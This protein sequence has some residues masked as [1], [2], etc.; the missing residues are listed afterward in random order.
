MAQKTKI[1]RKSDVYYLL[2]FFFVI[3]FGYF[4]WVG[5]Y[6]LF[7]QEQ[8][9]LF[10][11]SGEYFQ[12]YILK[13]GGFLELAGK[14]LT[15]FYSISIVGSLILATILTLPA[16]VLLKINQRLFSNKSFILLLFIPSSLL[17]LM[18]THYFHQIE[19]NLGFLMVLLYFLISILVQKKNIRLFVLALFPLFYYLVG[20]YAWIFLGMYSLYNL[21][22]EKRMLR[23]VYPLFLVG[24]ATVSFFVFK[25]ILFLQP[26]EQ[27]IQFPLPIVD[28]KNHKFIL[29]LLTGLLVLYPLLCKIAFLIKPKRIN[30]RPFILISA[31]IIFSITILFLS[32][33]YNSQTARVIQLQKLAFE[34]K[35]NEVLELHENYPSENLIG[36]YFYNI[37][38]SETD[39]LCDRLF[40]GRQDFSAN[41]LVLPW[42]SEH[43]N[44]GTYFF[45]SVGLI[46]E[47]HRWAYEEMVVYGLRPQNIKLLVKTNLINGNLEMANKYINILKKTIFYNDWAKEFEGILNNPGLI[48]SHPKLGEKIK[49]LPKEDF[50]I[51]I[52]DPQNN[53]PL[54]LKS[55]PNNKKAFEYEMAWLLLTKDVEAIVN[56]IKKMKELG[57]S[58]IP[59][60]IEE[61]VLIYF[62][63]KGQFPDLGGLSISNKTQVRFQ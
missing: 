32:K 49:I 41:S 30:T 23:F 18:Q 13:P 48:K 62:N 57:Y 15:Q 16:I 3:S 52:S 4:Y 43:L 53:I 47:A 7:F 19:Y 37:A 27:L 63:S 8:Q 9:S 29:V 44:W 59:L 6:L 34:E 51:Q 42:S 45:Y 55:N 40:N 50:F 33:F 11:F 24:I 61:A 10:I 35:W 20:A 26:S 25:E 58:R 54:L 56:N 21:F 60:H 38:L 14:F 12:E 2:T 36:Q 28:D 39:Q 22:F 1:A 31:L 5:N 17:L 46:N